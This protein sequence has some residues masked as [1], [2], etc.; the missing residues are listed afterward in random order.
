MLFAENSRT[1][2]REQ[3]ATV[4]ELIR[5]QISETQ[6]PAKQ[7]FEVSLESCR[8]KIPRFASVTHL[9]VQGRQL[10][11]PEGDNLRHDSLHRVDGDREADA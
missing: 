7:Q 6:T 2:V 9:N 8:S 10:Y 5:E 11:T 3:F 4:R 1:P